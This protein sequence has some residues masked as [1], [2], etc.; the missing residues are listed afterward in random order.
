[1]ADTLISIAYCV[2]S[3]MM[4]I[5]ILLMVVL[6]MIR[7]TTNEQKVKESFIELICLVPG[8]LIPLVEEELF[9]QLLLKY[10]AIVISHYFACTVIV[11]L[12]RTLSLYEEKQR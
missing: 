6:P 8:I 4:S 3:A 10:L 5:T 1:M 9:K 12:I 7:K 11:L 2:Y